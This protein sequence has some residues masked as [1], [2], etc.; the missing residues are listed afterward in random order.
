MPQHRTFDDKL[1]AAR[2]LRD[3]APIRREILLDDMNGTVHS[4]YGL[5]PNMTYV[6]GR[7]GIVLSKSM[8][9][10]AR[11][12]REYL[13]RYREAMQMGAVLMYSEHAEFRYP[14][15][16]LFMRLLERAGPSAVTEFKEGME[17]I[18]ER[19]RTRARQR[20]QRQ[21]QRPPH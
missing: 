12:V 1:A 2:R 21:Q 19:D 9:T 6:I 7:R 5:M 14:D 11:S 15:R 16:E 18:A 8:W 10:A 20:R 4:A 17:F 3:E 13:N